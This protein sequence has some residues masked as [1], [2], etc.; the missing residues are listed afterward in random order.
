MRDHHFE[1]IRQF[2]LHRELRVWEG[3]RIGLPQLPHKLSIRD[4]FRHMWE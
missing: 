1:D 2:F 4:S 3:T